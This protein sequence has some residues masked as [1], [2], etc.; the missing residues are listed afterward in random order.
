MP[1]TWTQYLWLQYLENQ[2]ER[3]KSESSLIVM[4]SEFAP[5]EYRYSESTEPT[6]PVLLFFIQTSNYIVRHTGIRT[7]L[8]CILI[9]ILAACA[10]INLVSV[11][12]E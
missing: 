9:I 1:L 5:P 12:F 4:S 11:A 6:N 3:R 8:Y 2:E 7:V 10:L